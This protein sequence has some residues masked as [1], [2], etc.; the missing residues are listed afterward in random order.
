MSVLSNTVEE[1]VRLL[2]E[3]TRVRV[4]VGWITSSEPPPVVTVVMQDSSAKPL[5]QSGSKLLYELRFQ[6]DIW[7]NSPKERDKVLDKIIQMIES[8]D[9]KRLGWFGVKVDGITDVEEEGV[10]RK[11]M[12]ISLKTLG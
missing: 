5:D 2:R 12:I 7:H 10:Y 1:L 3:A 6:L 8:G 11:L 4:K 9:V